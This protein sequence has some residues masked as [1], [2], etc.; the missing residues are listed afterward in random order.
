[1]KTS[2]AGQ[3][4]CLHRSGLGLDYF[5]SRIDRLTLQGNGRFTLITQ[6]R[7]R[8]SQAAQSLLNGQQVS[9]AAPEVRREGTFLLQGSS[10]LF[11]FD[12]GT[13]LQGQLVPNSTDLQIGQDTY[14]KTS[15][16]TL[17]PSAD[18]LKKDM[19]DIAKG[20]KIAGA[21]GGVAMKA[22][23]TI[24]STIQSAQTTQ[25]TNTQ[26][27]SAQPVQPTQSPYTNPPQS[28]PSPSYPHYQ[29]PYNPSQGY[30][31]QQPQQPPYVAPQTP[32]QPQQ[33]QL[34]Y[35]DQCGAPVRPGKRF[36]NQC[37]ARLE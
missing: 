13:Q 9:S 25:G 33:G 24:H 19:E 2:V 29:Q 12:D 20:L 37:G 8:V 26:T 34:L 32:Q 18:R 14:N 6:D 3:Y 23:K 31:A 11:N 28:A 27:G 7:S 22:A 10:I 4:E 5:T 15:D 1:M 30:Q 35:C 36:C 17:L 21:I 16:S